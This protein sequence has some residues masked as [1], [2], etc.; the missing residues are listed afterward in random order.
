VG[1]LKGQSKIAMVFC[2]PEISWINSAI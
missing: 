2:L 1:F